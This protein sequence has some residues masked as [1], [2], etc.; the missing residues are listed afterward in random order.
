M[1]AAQKSIFSESI[2]ITLSKYANATKI[3][4][5]L[6]K[7]YGRSNPLNGLPE[8][9]KSPV[10]WTRASPAGL[11]NARPGYTGE[12]IWTKARRIEL[13]SDDALYLFVFA[14]ICCLR[15]WEPLSGEKRFPLSL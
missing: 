5:L 15:E 6:Q 13:D 10:A 3:I 1:T 11:E 2:G 14:H 4:R 12:D 9:L 7:H 8:T